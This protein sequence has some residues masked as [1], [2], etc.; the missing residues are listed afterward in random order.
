MGEGAAPKAGTPP[1]SAPA[2]IQVNVPANTS[3]TV[4][5]IQVKGN[6]LVSPALPTGREF[7][8]DLRAQIV[9]DGQTISQSQRVAVRAGQTTNVNF[10]FDAGT[11]ASNR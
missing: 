9:R 10:T 3:L 5:G 11:V 4:D 8:Y 2:V 1:V 6:K 7:H